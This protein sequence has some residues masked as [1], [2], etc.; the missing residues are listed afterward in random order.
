MLAAVI[1]ASGEEIQDYNLNALMSKTGNAHRSVEGAEGPIQVIVDVKPSSYLGQVA[2]RL[3]AELEAMRQE[4]IRERLER[5][6]AQRA[7][8]KKAAAAA[9]A[10]AKALAAQ[11]AA[12]AKKAKEAAEAKAKEAAAAKA[13]GAATPAKGESKME[14]KDEKRVLEPHA[15][16]SDN[17]CV[18]PVIPKDGKLL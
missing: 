11:K 17:G 4:R 18:I 5:E 7:A 6:A 8:A 15:T 2:Q 1:G 14:E 13:T 12:A 10:K 3:Q 9:A 16:H